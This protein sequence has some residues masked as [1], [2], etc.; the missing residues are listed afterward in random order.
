MIR[1][2]E[3]FGP[4]IQGEGV[5]AGLQVMFI[6][7]QGCD[8]NCI[9][10]DTKES[11]PVGK[12]SSVMTYI[13]IVEELVLKSLNT[14]HVVITGGNPALQDLQ[15][16]IELLHLN[17]YTVHLETQGTLFPYWMKNVDLVTISPK[18]PSS[19]QVYDVDNLS[20]NL[21]R[22]WILKTPIANEEDYQWWKDNILPLDSIQYLSVVNA[23]PHV[24]FSIEQVLNT[25]K[26]LVDRVLED[27]II[28]V[29]V[30]VIPQ[31][32]TL[33]WGNKKGV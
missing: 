22:G 4:T 11:W 1:V 19:G 5:V 33:I 25:Y 32:H 27:D 24:G 2:A 26:W 29:D 18:P 20:R 7:L 13:Q 15:N 14:K 28:G 31:L 3:I 12:D 9:W 30:Y 8:G 6:R 23:N 16:L 17:Q 10:C 21:Y